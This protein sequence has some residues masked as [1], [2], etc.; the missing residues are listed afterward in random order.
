MSDTKWRIIRQDSNGNR[1]IEAKDLSDLAADAFVK[2]REAQIGFHHQSVWK[3][4]M[5]EA[6]PYPFVPVRLVI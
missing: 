4:N 3:Q 5:A 1:V 2:A 6:A